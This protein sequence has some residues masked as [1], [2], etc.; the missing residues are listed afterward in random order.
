[1]EKKHPI[2]WLVTWMTTLGQ[3]AITL[4]IP[5]FP[6]I[7]EELQIV[8]EGVKVTL[9]A[10]L[11]GFGFCQFFYGPLSD[12]FGRK[13]PLLFGIALF[14]LACLANI[15]VYSL[16]LFL[17]L[18]FIQGVGA[19]SVITLGRAILRDSFSGKE[20]ASAT[21]HLSMGFAIG[22][23]VSPII[24]A[25][26]LTLFGW[27]SDFLFLLLIGISLLFLVWIKLPETSTKPLAAGSWKEAIDH[28][29]HRYK[30]I[31]RDGQFWKFL[32]GG[33]FA[34]SVAISWNIL[35]PFLIQVHFGYSANA[36]AWMSLLV[37]ISYYFSAHFN[38]T[39]VMK[40]HFGRIFL[41]AIL[42]IG[43]SGLAMVMAPDGLL[44]LLIPM[45]IATFGQALIFS[46]TIA[47]ALQNYSHISGKASAVFSGLQMILVSFISGIMAV[48]PEKTLLLGLTLII[49]SLLSY[50]SL[51]N[52][53]SKKI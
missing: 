45:I 34:Y 38:R 22:L 48:F 23:G 53:L 29:S 47:G 35:T 40:F 36:Y 13:P 32:L 25:Y 11:L 28:T 7:S 30:Q 9:T 18:R 6:T 4:Y 2:P 41:F 10:F 21:S 5:A 19:G 52:L 37:A 50:F 39:L 46:N 12:R 15:F 27:R 8:P 14:C 33:V 44:Y 17:F 3:A 20:L 43:L 42:L 51:A 26:L 49:L 31:L 16:P 24:G 1:M